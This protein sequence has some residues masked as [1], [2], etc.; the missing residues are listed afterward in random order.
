MRV[1]IPEPSLWDPISPFLYEG[2]IELWQ[3]GQRCDSVQVR[4]GLRWFSG[5]GHRFRINGHPL[6]PMGAERDRCTDEEARRLR[7]EGVNTLV[8]PVREDTRALWDLAD[9]LG[10][11]IIGRIPTRLESPANLNV[12]QPDQHPSCLGWLL[13]VDDQEAGRLAET[14]AALTAARPQTWIGVELHRVPEAL[15]EGLH[16]VLCA[17]ELLP[18]LITIELPKLVR[19]AAGVLTIV[20][21]TKGSQP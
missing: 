4:H 10:F 2:P 9:R 8:V 3:D 14:V 11:L 1:V 17:E 6:T 12:P 18:S 5:T 15:P 13:D 7:K 20:P 21:S 19:T 16:F